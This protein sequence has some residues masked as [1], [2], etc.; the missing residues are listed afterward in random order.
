MGSNL[1]QEY[2]KEIISYDKDSG[3]ISW[4][5]PTSKRARKGSYATGKDSGGYLRVGIN[6]VRYRIHRIVWLYVYGKW[7]EKLIDHIN[8]V[9]TDNRI[10]N[11]RDASCS[12]NIQN[13]R[14]ARSDNKNG[15]LGVTNVG[16]KWRAKININGECKHVGYFYT[17]ELAHEA[18]LNAK[19]GIHVGCTI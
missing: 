14:K 6:G 13:V 9:K 16:K 17:K 19:R 18:Y 10:E 1:T 8:G 11:L 2:L 3:L 15:T 4:I 12:M 7:P 5:K